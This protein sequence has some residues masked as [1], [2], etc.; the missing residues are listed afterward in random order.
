MRRKLSRA[1]STYDARGYLIRKRHKTTKRRTKSRKGRSKQDN[2]VNNNAFKFETFIRPVSDVM[3]QLDKS[4]IYIEKV[5]WQGKV[6]ARHL[7][8]SEKCVVHVVDW[9]TDRDPQ[10]AIRNYYRILFITRVLA[11]SRPVSH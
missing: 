11:M 4:F 6:V 1:K 8:D 9:F 3:S 7:G 2:P 10:V 5:H